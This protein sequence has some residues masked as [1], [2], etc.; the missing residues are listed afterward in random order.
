MVRKI[1]YL[2]WNGLPRGSPRASDGRDGRDDM[3]FWA[4][5]LTPNEVA[6]LSIGRNLVIKQASLSIK[7]ETK[8]EAAPNVL[9]IRV[10]ADRADGEFV[11]CKLQEGRVEHCPLELCISPGDEAQ[12]RLTGP[13]KVHLTGFLDMDDAD[14]W[15]DAEERATAGAAPGT[16]QA[17]K[18]GKAPAPAKKSAKR[19]AA[20]APPVKADKKTKSKR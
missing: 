18:Q 5:E 8:G 12:L 9:S 14:D 6:A 20:D 15:E 11:V 4:L 17:S 16:W 13:H 7:K 19:S 2:Y 1:S 10:A 3:A